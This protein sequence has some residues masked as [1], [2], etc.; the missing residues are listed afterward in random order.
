MLSG[1]MNQDPGRDTGPQLPLLYEQKADLVHATLNGLT[2][3]ALPTNPEAIA[4]PLT[5]LANENRILQQPDSP[6]QQAVRRY[7][8]GED[9]DV[10]HL[11][12]YGEQL[13]QG[14]MT[15]PKTLPLQIRKK[16]SPPDIADVVN[17]AQ[18]CNAIFSHVQGT[19]PGGH[20]SR[21]VERARNELFPAALMAASSSLLFRRTDAQFSRDHLMQIYQRM[22]GDRA[23]PGWSTIDV[24]HAMLMDRVALQAVVSHGALSREAYEGGNRNYYN[25]PLNAEARHQ[26]EVQTAE[27]IERL[28]LLKAY[29]VV[30]FEVKG[31]QL[32]LPW[33]IAVVPPLGDLEGG[34]AEG[35]VADFMLLT[36]D[37]EHVNIAFQIERTD[38]TGGGVVG[39]GDRAAVMRF[40]LHDDGR[41]TH[42]LRYH[43]IPNSQTEEMFRETGADD[44][45]VKLRGLFTALA[46]DAVVPDEAVPDA[47]VRGSVAQSF[48]ERGQEPPQDRVT[49]LLLRRRRAL[50][51]ANVG[52]RNRQPTG[53]P[54]TY[55]RERRGYVM[56]MREGYRARATAE[57][58]AR[59]WHRSRNLAFA[60]LQEHETW[61]PEK[62]MPTQGPEVVQRRAY[63]RENSETARHLG[64]IG[65]P[66]RRRRGG[67]GRRS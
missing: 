52:P 62:D 20:D 36:P 60:G 53:W 27:V 54:Q 42:G 65:L 63:F 64:A 12:S 61:V 25:R 28:H 29:P 17:I 35:A 37:D 3:Q 47:Q 19:M 23:I 66:R 1:H 41:V 59:E 16:V 56:R 18:A 21:V 30:S 32:G 31:E 22:M 8:A 33:D 57:H 34:Y 48:R 67:P 10:F 40:R 14:L 55:T 45:F 44:A 43:N 39:I 51:R 13:V 38:E 7:L 49:K 11:Y 6:E 4:N 46:F 58:E 15:P 2:E 9:T 5:V 26:L 24:I 50:E